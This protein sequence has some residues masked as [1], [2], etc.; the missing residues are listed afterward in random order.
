MSM[1][2]LRSSCVIWG[3]SVVK[4]SQLRAEYQEIINYQSGQL[5]RDIQSGTVE[6][7]SA[8]YHAVL[9]RN[10]MLLKMRGQTSALGVVIATILKPVVM[11]YKGLV[12]KFSR[13]YGQPVELLREEERIEV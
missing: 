13:Q 3:S 9:K 10:T 1:R 2:A 8:A 11:N 4:D 7:G 5:L 6:R 12:T